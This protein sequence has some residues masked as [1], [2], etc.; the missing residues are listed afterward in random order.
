MSRLDDL[1]N[2]AEIETFAD[3]ITGQQRQIRQHALSYAHYSPA[4]T[5]APAIWPTLHCVC[6]WWAQ[7]STWEEAGRD[8]DLH[9]AATEE[10]EEVNDKFE[11]D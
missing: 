9:F 10:E 2:Q 11:E 1:Y 4:Y 7:A 3:G 6:G 8:F 5:E